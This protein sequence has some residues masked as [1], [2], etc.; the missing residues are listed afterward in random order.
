MRK[1]LQTGEMYY[2]A[3]LSKDKN[4]QQVFKDKKDFH[5]SIAKMVF[6]LPGEVDDYFKETFKTERQSAKAMDLII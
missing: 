4:L 1:L 2:A 6:D 3:V 5:S